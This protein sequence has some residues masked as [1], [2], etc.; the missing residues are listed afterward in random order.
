[1]DDFMRH[2]KPSNL[3][4][5]ISTSQRTEVC[6]SH[7]HHQVSKMAS[8][9][10][11]ATLFIFGLWASQTTARS[12]FEAPV[13]L[14]H[15]QWMVRYG[16]VYKSETEKQM[17]SKIYNHNVEYI[18][19]FNKAGTHTYTLGI[20]AFTDMTN[21]EFR[22]RNGYKSPVA[23][24][25]TEFMYGSVTDVPDSVDWRDL[26]AVTAV[27][28]QGMCGSCWAFSAVGSMEGIV[29]IATNEL[30]A[31]SEQQVVD[32]DTHGE[33]EGCMGGYMYTAMEFIINSGGLANNTAYP[34][35][36]DDGNCSTNVTIAAMSGTFVN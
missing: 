25:P 9:V 32:C 19:S 11:F 29:Q 23:P 14:T 12:L 3:G 17:R 2:N 8:K 36:G 21:E 7:S 18:E 16:R 34:Y 1:M 33:D 26:G 22:V 10:V 27:K 24:K 28:D 13:K 35:R 15:E 6:L 31:L 30:I 4:I 5:S 20:N